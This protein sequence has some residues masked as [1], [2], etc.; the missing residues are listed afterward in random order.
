[1]KR[2]QGKNIVF[3]GKDL[4]HFVTDITKSFFELF[5]IH[6]VTCDSLRSHVN[7]LKVVND[8]AERGLAL[9][10]KFNE[11]IKDE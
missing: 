11:S 10:K 3:E 6:D 4:S 8:T 2:L 7:A 1:M 9:I 5:G